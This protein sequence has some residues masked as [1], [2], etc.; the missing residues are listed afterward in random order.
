MKEKPE[1]PIVSFASRDEWERWLEENHATSPGVW[2]KISKKGTTAASVTYPEALEAALCY[3]WIDGQKASL[4]EEN[5]L[6]RFTQ[7]RPGS[8][9]SK[10]N[11]DKAEELIVQGRMKPAGLQEVERARADGRWEAAYA[12]QRSI[13]IPDDL[14]LALAENQP[15]Q[16]FF[17]TLDSRNRYAIL[18]RIQ[19]A[20][21]PETRS[22]RIATFVAML[23]EH[24]KIYP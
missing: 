15:A 18:Y 16:E 23:S 11:R 3:G 5:W 22:R 14:R 8:K 13:T 9:W 6:Q 12:G 1:I 20:K 2:L 21:K 17:T 24:K 4:N 19:D 7:R 10:I